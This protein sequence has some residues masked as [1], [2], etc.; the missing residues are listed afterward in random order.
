MITNQ[1]VITDPIEVQ[2]IRNSIAEARLTLRSGTFNGRKISAQEALNIRRSIE[3]SLIKIGESLIQN[4]TVS[5]NFTITD[6]TP[7]G[8]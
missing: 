1:Q 2:K 8:Y 7:K 4:K 6:V 3:S 5:P